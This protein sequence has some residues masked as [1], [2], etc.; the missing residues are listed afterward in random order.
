MRSGRY[1]VRSLLLVSAAATYSPYVVL[2]FI[3]CLR[4]LLIIH[5]KPSRLM[6]IDLTISGEDSSANLAHG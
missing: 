6:H 5:S 3:M 2:L 1:V 4:S